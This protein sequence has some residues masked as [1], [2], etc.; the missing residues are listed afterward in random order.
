MEQPK[1]K[2]FVRVAQEFFSGGK[3]GRKVEIAEF[4]ALT[5][6]DKIELSE[7]LNSAGY[8]H[9]PYTGTLTQ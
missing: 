8:S 3:Y 7:M 6:E 9:E 4:K 5:T 2:S 1:G